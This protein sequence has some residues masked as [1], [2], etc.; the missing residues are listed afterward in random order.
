MKAP[1]CSTRLPKLRLPKA[2][3]CLFLAVVVTPAA[4]AHDFWIQPIR[5][6]LPLDAPAFFTVE[7]GHGPDRHRSQ[8]SETRINRLE[9]VDAQGRRSD[10]RDG[11]KIGGKA[12]DLVATL[13]KPGAY[14]ILLETDNAAQSHLPAARFNEYLRREGLTPAI[15]ARQRLGDAAR[16][17][18]ENYSRHAKSIVQVGAIDPAEHAQLTCRFG[19]ELEIVPEQSP[20]LLKPGTPLSIL[21]YYR[22]RTLPGALVKLTDLGQDTEQLEAHVTDQD[23][24]AIFTIAR[25]GT[26]LLNVVWTRPQPKARLTDFNTSFSSLTFRTATR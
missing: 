15:K 22:G 25:P 11:L 8:I 18:A 20:L 16:D 10:L 3:A 4:L 14:V 17:G 12:A 1:C 26:W 24:R 19:L 5:W 2:F 21:V 23:G 13:R 9:A 6:Q 7:T